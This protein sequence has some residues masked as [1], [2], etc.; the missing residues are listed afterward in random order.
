MSS[1]AVQPV[2][3]PPEPM[4]QFSVDEFHR[5]IE[6]GILGKEDR[7]ELLEGWLVAKMV[8]NPKHDSTVAAMHEAVQNRLP[9]GWHIRVQSAITTQDSEPEPDLV[10]ASGSALGYASAH[11]GP[12]DIA[13]VVEIA[14]ST[15]RLDRGLKLRLDAR[16]G[17]K[18]YWI[19][20]LPDRC[21]EVYADP[22]GPVADP[23][24]RDRKIVAGTMM[25]SLPSVLQPTS[26][27]PLAEIFG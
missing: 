20:N 27:I 1:I 19:V 16:A 13:L 12:A 10:V 4:R 15:L 8:H 3:P 17:I 9:R 7:V 26:E 21:V 11:P 25:L 22:A 14:D 5:M 6:A 2:S 18:T 23:E 24:Y